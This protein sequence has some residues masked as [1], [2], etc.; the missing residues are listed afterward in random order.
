MQRN[1][2]TV[3]YATEVESAWSLMQQSQLKVLPV[4]DRS[5]RVIGIVTQYDFM[6]N[7]QLTPHADLQ[8]NWLAFI[9]RTPAISTDKPEAI[10]HIMTRKVKTLSAS[11]PFSELIPLLLIEGH[12]HVPIVDDE[13][14]F[15]GMVSQTNLISALF[16]RQAVPVQFYVQAKECNLT[17]E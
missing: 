11:T 6:K 9:K 2:V 12:R 13:Q 16:N 5:R 14:R 3:E 1:I 17:R 10:G 15:V 4:L 7:L 8:H